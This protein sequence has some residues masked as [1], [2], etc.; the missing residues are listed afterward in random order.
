MSNYRIVAIHGP[1]RIV[2]RDEKGNETLRRASHLKACELKQK[3]ASMTPEQ[4]EYNKFGRSTKLLIH[5]KDIPDLQ[6]ARESRIKGEIL[7]NTEILM[8]EVNIT[9]GR[10]EYGE[11]PPNKQ[12]DEAISSLSLNKQKL[13]ECSG[14]SKERSKFLPEARNCTKNQMINLSEQYIVGSVEERSKQDISSNMQLI[15]TGDSN[16]WFYS[17][18]NCVI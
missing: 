3:V 16:T 11:I 14:L 9:S 12:A 4:E 7:P 13:V 6:F 17:P 1:N 18:I 8:I 2:V 15:D 5:P 10:D